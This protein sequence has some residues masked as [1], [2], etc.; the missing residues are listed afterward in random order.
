MNKIDHKAINFCLEQGLKVVEK[1][2][3][4][5]QKMGGIH[6]Q[7]AH[8]Y[9]T[10]LQE[11]RDRIKAIDPNHF[12]EHQRELLEGR[13]TEM[14]YRSIIDGDQIQ[15]IINFLLPRKKVKK[16]QSPNSQGKEK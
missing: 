12:W 11:L 15:T 4:K 3:A 16:N 8:D 7:L 13:I 9:E 10:K 6:H 14:K 1:E 2:I 5:I